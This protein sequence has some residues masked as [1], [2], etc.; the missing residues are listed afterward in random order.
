MKIHYYKTYQRAEIWNYY[1]LMSD[2]KPPACEVVNFLNPQP[3]IEL[4]EYDLDDPAS[5]IDFDAFWQVGARIEAEEY[6]AAYQ[7]ATSQSFQLY[8]NGRRQ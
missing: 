3:L 7:L 6:Q 4:R 2:R 1:K 5:R 8:I